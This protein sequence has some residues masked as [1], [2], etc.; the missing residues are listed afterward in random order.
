MAKDI[1]AIGLA[2]KIAKLHKESASDAEIHRSLQTLCVG[3]GIAE[4]DAE[5]RLQQAFHIW[6]AMKEAIGNTS[7]AIT[8]TTTPAEQ[9]LLPD[10]TSIPSTTPEQ[11]PPPWLAT[12]LTAMQSTSLKAQSPRRQRQPD[13]DMFDGNRKQYQVFHQ[14]LTAKVKNDEKDFENN[15]IACDYAFARLKGS[16]ATLTLPFMSRMQREDQW[17]FNKLLAFFNQMFGDPHQEERARDKLWS[18]KQG[19]KNVRNYAM[20]FQEQLLQSGSVL[21]ENTK[22]M[23][24]RKGLDYRLQDKLIGTAHRTL[25]QLSSMAIDISDQLYRMEYH[26]KG[27]SRKGKESSAERKPWARHQ[28]PPPA[29]EDAMQG[30]EYTGK[31]GRTYLSS[32]EIEKLKREGRCFN[33][34]QKGHMATFC[35]EDRR[36]HQKK[37]VSV[38]KA[39]SSKHKESKKKKK[40]KSQHVLEEPS[41]DGEH[42]EV[43]NSSQDDSDLGKE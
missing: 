14:Q 22:M 7:P 20:E 12:L 30:V 2:V 8:P 34:K 11:Q 19:R 10:R 23:L 16:A 37:T 17:D 35:T 26:S 39:T 42:S 6:N 40:G 1:S 21:D 4:Q 29:M 9:P 15:K 27:S 32:S 24:F 3:Q 18:M 43:S 13:P 41:S 38:S 25:E 31:T 33:C 5:A 28:S 36:A